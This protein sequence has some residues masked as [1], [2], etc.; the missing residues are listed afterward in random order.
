[1][2]AP[3]RYNW[4]LA[5]CEEHEFLRLSDAMR[6]LKT[7]ISTVRRD[8]NELASRKLV[9]RI[10]GGIKRNK[11]ADPK[12]LPYSLREI[13]YSSEKD[14]IA[15]YAATLPASNDVIIVD[16]G[17]TTFHLANHITGVPLRIITVS[18]SLMVALAKKHNKSRDVEIFIPGGVF[19][20]NLDIVL[21]PDTKESLSRAHAQWSFLAVDGINEHGI[22]N[23]HYLT[24]E[25]KLKMIENGEKVV[26]LADHSKIG[27]TAMIHICG[28]DKID[29]LITDNYPENSPVLDNIR[30]SGVEVIV[31]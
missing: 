23:M 13:Q 10:H 29:M 27:K 7:S 8:F 18:V 6:S 5:Y 31:V 21:G 4:Y 3:E 22:S 1:M 30:H 16:G 17:T 19:D 15:S 11:V 9:R 14:Q 28:L 2:L 26:V 20:T 25:S 12:V 24:T